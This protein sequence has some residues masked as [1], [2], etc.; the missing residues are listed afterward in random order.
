MKKLSIV[1]LVSAVSTFW[2]AGCSKEPLNH[3]TAEETRIYVTNYDSVANFSAYKTYSIADSVAVIDN[4]Q[5]PGALR[6]GPGL[7]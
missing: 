4:G 3:L 2:F 6:L 1:F 7:Y 5:H